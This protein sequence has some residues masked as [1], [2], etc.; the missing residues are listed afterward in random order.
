MSADR[1]HLWIAAVLASCASLLAGL[2]G[3]ALVATDPTGLAQLAYLAAA[4]ATLAGAVASGLVVRQRLTGRG[5]VDE[6]IARHGTVVCLA[7]GTVLSSTT[8]GVDEPDWMLLFLG[9]G[10]GTAA[11]GVAMVAVA[12]RAIRSRIGLDAGWSN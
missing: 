1:V 2:A 11:V 3:W 10:L 12:P 9:L 8:A 4:V 7:S 6:A 5:D